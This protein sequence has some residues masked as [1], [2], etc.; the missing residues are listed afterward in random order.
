MVVKQQKELKN[1]LVEVNECMIYWNDKSKLN[2]LK[3][4]RQVAVDEGFYNGFWKPLLDFLIDNYEEIELADCVQRMYDGLYLECDDYS[5]FRKWSNNY[6]RSLYNMRFSTP[7]QYFKVTVGNSIYYLYEDFIFD[8][9]GWKLDDSFTS[10]L[11]LYRE[12]EDD[13]VFH[14]YLGGFNYYDELDR[15]LLEDTGGRQFCLSNIDSVRFM[16]GDFSIEIVDSESYGEC[17][18]LEG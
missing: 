5:C 15:V 16:I 11:K 10:A 17:V 18:K 9:V 8:H 2:F 3:S 14:E 12:H 6:L 13:Y 1:I 7:N 4:W